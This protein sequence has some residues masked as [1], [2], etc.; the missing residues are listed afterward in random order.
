MLNFCDWLKKFFV[1]SFPSLILFTRSVARFEGWYKL[2]NYK[3]G[4]SSCTRISGPDALSMTGSIDGA[5]PGQ[6]AP[7]KP[8]VSAAAALAKTQP[9]APPP[10][11][12]VLEASTGTFS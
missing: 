8:T 7:P 3:L 9:Q 5:S 2:L 4:R 6:A 11:V 10:S 1:P 12:H